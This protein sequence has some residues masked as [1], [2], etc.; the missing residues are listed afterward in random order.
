MMTNTIAYTPDYFQSLAF[1]TDYQTLA[2]Y[3]V[4]IY[5]PKTVVEFGC[6]PG[7]L[8]REL[9]K[10]GVEVTAVDGFSRPDFTELSV[11]FSPLDLNNADA[12]AQ[13]FADKRF[14]LAISLEVA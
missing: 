10:L 1:D 3:I 11:E 13:F 7:H 5:R 2:S 14:D 4:E 8:S 9:A 12:I 6:G